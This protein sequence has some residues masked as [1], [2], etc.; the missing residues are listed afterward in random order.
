MTLGL[1]SVIHRW[2]ELKEE[3]GA[4]HPLFWV[5]PANSLSLSTQWRSW[6]CSDSLGVWNNSHGCYSHR[7]GQ[8]FPHFSAQHLLLHWWCNGS[9]LVY[10]IVV[11]TDFCTL[12]RNGLGWE[13]SSY[14]VNA[15]GEFKNFP[16]V[17]WFC[18]N[19]AKCLYL[20]FTRMLFFGGFWPVP[21]KCLPGRKT[22]LGFWLICFYSGKL[23]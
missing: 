15:K 4:H 16:G 12:I 13:E 6:L 9:E 1:I 14:E 5:I 19:Y 2:L 23:K 21:Q 18:Q 22:N 20:S 17:N 3:P 7:P 10:R 11:S 8:S